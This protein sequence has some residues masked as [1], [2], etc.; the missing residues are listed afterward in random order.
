MGRVCARGESGPIFS[1]FA[2]HFELHLVLGGRG[3]FDDHSD[4]G[5]TDVDNT[6]AVLVTNVVT[7]REDGYHSRVV[8]DTQPVCLLLMSTEDVGEPVVAHEEV[9]R[10]VPERPEAGTT[11]VDTESVLVKLRASIRGV[12]PDEI[13]HHLATLS[14]QLGLRETGGLHDTVETGEVRGVEQLQPLVGAAQVAGDTSV[15]GEH[16]T[17]DHRRCGEGGEDIVERGPHILALRLTELTVAFV[18]ERHFTVLGKVTVHLRR[19][20]V[21][22][23]QEHLL[24]GEDL[25]AEEVG[26]D[27]D[28]VVTTV[29]VVAQ[30]E[31][32]TGGA[33]NLAEGNKTVQEI[34]EVVEVAV[35]VP[36]YV[37]GAAETQEHALLHQDGLHALAH[38]EK[39]LDVVRLAHTATL[40][41]AALVQRDR[42]VKEGTHRLLVT[43]TNLRTSLESGHNSTRVGA[44][45]RKH[46]G[47]L[48]DV[49]CCLEGATTAG[50]GDGRVGVGTS[51]PRHDLAD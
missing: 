7:S 46:V 49:E 32:G 36:E 24:G 1:S 15:C 2:G 41:P 31:E 21:T 19:L 51:G 43:S 42:H 10:L 16:L 20:V 14:I 22:A 9:S 4:T 6:G 34:V 12:A 3:L 28:T 8:T 30:E 33:L 44:L 47:V 40:L 45:V 17:V 39:L 18:A 38:R 48:G 29:N 13:D 37:Q 26:G 50:S 27:L 25:Q 11:R 35:Q 23:Q 5:V